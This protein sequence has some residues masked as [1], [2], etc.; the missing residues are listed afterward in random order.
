MFSVLLS[1]RVVCGTFL[2]LV[3]LV[4]LLAVGQWCRGQDAV[5]TS[6]PAFTTSALATTSTPATTSAP[7]KPLTPAE[8]KAKFYYAWV[9]VP[10]LLT[11]VLA[12]WW[13]QVVPAL[14]IG[15]LAAAYMLAGAEEQ[16][17]FGGITLS[18]LRLAV[19][20]YFLGA[21][22][23][24]DHLR[25]IVFTLSI[26]GM[27]GII[28]AN[29]GTP[30]IVGI[31]ARWA[32]SRRRG[33]IATWFAGLIVFFDD[34]ANA[35][36]VGPAMR[37]VS[38]RLKISRAKLAYLVDSTAA[39]VA[40]IALIGTWIGTEILYI[41][42]G[43][44]AIGQKPAFLA[45]VTLDSGFAY[46]VFI[47]SLAYRFYPILALVMVLLI[48]LF[49]RDFGPMRRA[50]SDCV[51]GKDTAST[52][53]AGESTI[54]STKAWYAG[55]PVL[56]LLG[57]TIALLIQTGWTR[58]NAK[59]ELKREAYIAML[60][61]QPGD[62]TTPAVSAEEAH[63][64][65]SGTALVREV[66]TNGDAYRSLLWGAVT[67]LILATVISLASRTLNL[68]QSV[69]A[70]TSNMARMFTTVLILVFAWTLST[71]MKDLGLGFVARD[72]LA[73]AKFDPSYLPLLVFI[74]ACVV[75]F[76]TGTSYG[77]MGILCPAVVPIAAGLM[78][79]M[80][81]AEAEP[82]F[83]AAVGAV[84]AGSVFGDHCSPISDTTVLSALASE[85]S[86][87][88][89]VWTQMPYALTVAVVSV[90]C[91]DVLCRYLNQPWWIGLI[92][93]T[94]A[95]VLIVLIVGRRPRAPGESEPV[96]PVR[97]STP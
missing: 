97:V 5:P 86:L 41:Q 35:M 89:H 60:V 61:D 25:I 67:S 18:G 14:A 6:A 56:V 15:V 90:V 34:Y 7:A 54:R 66:I 73:H 19:E 31:V 52:S 93:G 69:E 65:P 63:P 72:M 51:A 95:L 21:L 13:R 40:S 44:E 9:V 55:V 10:P 64:L 71:A 17:Q 82:I 27:V 32:S 38:D 92:A 80:P 20:G 78:M 75:S 59:L 58:M 79:D 74:S 48:G 3:A 77:T 45:D 42:Q 87:E 57:V 88:S 16:P 2:G 81:A 68:G 24:T 4:A 49:D 91:G 94:V 84:L 37:P 28:A 70:A 36:V 96:A 12:I 29:G 23:D 22:A 53:V 33:Q 43:L 47:R 62:M 39:P 85:C 26:G 30:A 1:H 83:Y 11:I 8:K 50:E 76:A 46:E